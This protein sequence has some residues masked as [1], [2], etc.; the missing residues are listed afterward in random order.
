MTAIHRWADI[1]AVA[2]STAQLQYDQIGR[3]RLTRDLLAAYSIGAISMLKENPSLIVTT[4][5]DVVN[6]YDDVISLR[7]ALAFAAAGIRAADHTYTIT[8]ADSLAGSAI[9][10][11]GKL[12][13]L[14]V[15]AGA[16]TILNP[17]T[18]DGG[19]RITIDGGRSSTRVCP[20][21]IG[22]DNY[23]FL[24][25]LIFED[26]GN[27]KGLGGAIINAG[28]L[29]VTNTTFT[30]NGISGQRGGGAIYNTGNLVIDN[31]AFIGNQSSEGGGGA[32]Y[33]T[34]SLVVN[35]ATFSRNLA[36]T[37]RGNSGGGAIWNSNGQVVVAN[38]TFTGNRTN[39]KG[40][41]IYAENGTLVVL[42]STIT[43][44]NGK[45]DGSGIYCDSAELAIANSIILGNTGSTNIKV[46]GNNGFSAVYLVTSE[47][48]QKTP[49][50]SDHNFF[51][52]QDDPFTDGNPRKRTVNGVEQ[53]YFEVK[54]VSV[55]ETTTDGTKLRS[56]Y[57]KNG[58]DIEYY[59]KDSS[60]WQTLINYLKSVPTD[61]QFSYDQIGRDR[62]MYDRSQTYSIGAV[63]M[64]R[65]QPSLTVTTDLDLVDPCD[66]RISLREAALYYAHS[67]DTVTFAGKIAAVLD[68]DLE[69]KFDLNLNFG[70]TGASVSSG[71]D[72][73][74]LKSEFAL[75]VQGAAAFNHLLLSGKGDLSFAGSTD[76]S[77]TV[78][79]TGGGVIYSSAD[80]QVV[81]GGTYFDLLLTGT[82][83]DGAEVKEFGGDIAVANSF[84]ASGTA[85]G[86]Y[87]Q[88]NGNH[89]QLT[90][91]KIGIVIRYTDIHDL[92]AAESLVLDD[93]NTI[94]GTTNI[95]VYLNTL[96]D[97]GKSI[98]YGQ[99][100]SDAGSF[101]LSAYA[102]GILLGGDWSFLNGT[103]RPQVKDSDVTSYEIILGGYYSKATL[104]ITPK[105]I[106][107]SGIAADNRV[108][109]G[110]TDAT[111]DYTNAVLTGKLAGDTLSV[112][113][114]GVFADKNAGVG[115]TVNLG[116]LTLSGADVGN[117]ILAGTGQQTSTTATI[118]PRDITVTADEQTKIAGTADP[119]LTYQLT[120]GSLV[121]GDG[122]PAN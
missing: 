24:N 45:K 70:D 59:S 12:A 120:E 71:R 52:C 81:Y 18:I 117:Y 94:A 67:G 76:G 37:N 102:R 23:V 84:D 62:L 90:L 22:A 6:P 83:A 34:G 50:Y 15:A 13:S 82:G 92:T 48:P 26:G 10:I 30:G 65:E 5:Q 36:D 107:V 8:F 98:T 77:A 69:L 39:G 119:E 17:L 51:D 112:S 100:L 110:T 40:G 9:E 68:H 85:N 16:F 97:S 3:A 11:D 33:N 14:T 1:G 29:T 55:V 58:C 115:K 42:N 111:L 121:D 35:N 46:D 74:A 72:G 105:Q 116:A 21:E 73:I 4:D 88:I 79:R 66:G 113:A 49:D 86:Q 106:T 103:T 104:T 99:T 53:L 20:L 64:L 63:N 89:Y 95:A 114:T 41:A 43:Q 91:P 57:G 118:T 61:E 60:N 108:Y 38:T 56:Y 122:F 93:T 25:G 96:F 44:N 101:Q 2:L 87:L 27:A 109:D 28:N 78:D 32:I 54:D 80:S 75:I 7:E 19:G 47:T 31:A